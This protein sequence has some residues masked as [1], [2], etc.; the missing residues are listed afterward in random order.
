[1]PGERG[2]RPERLRAGSVAARV[3]GTVG[4]VLV[5]A[6]NIIGGNG[7]LGLVAFTLWALLPYG[8]LAVA[9]PAL[10]GSW[11][12]AGAGAAMLAVEAGVRASVFLHPRG[13]TAAVALVFSPILVAVS[14]VPGGVGGWLV[15]RAWRTGHLPLRIAGVIA[16]ATALGLTVLGLA[17]PD[18]FPT[19]VLRRRSTLARIGEPRIVHG[20]SAFEQVPVSD[21]A[22]WYV[23]GALDE[24]PGEAIA[25]VDN[26]GA[27]LLDPGDFRAR[28]HVDFG[29]VHGGIWNWFSTLARLDGHLVVVQ[30]GGGYSDVE[31]QE[32]DGRV[33]WSYRPDPDL[34]PTALK[35]ADLDG[36][37]ELEFYASDHSATVRLD[38]A[39][40]EV[41][42]RPTHMAHLVGVA[43]RTPASRAWVVAAESGRRVLIWDETGQLLAE[44]PLA[45][46]DAVYGVV[47]WPEARALVMGGAAARGIALDGTPLFEIPLGDFYLSDV[48]AVQLTPGAPPHLALVGSA[49]RDVGRWRLLLVSSERELVYDEIL[50]RYV[51][52]LK[53]RRA[54]GGETL[55]VGGGGLRA[56]RPR[57]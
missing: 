46:R 25:V 39:G 8:L 54:D 44:L 33:L 56:L 12:A 20:A 30:T 21:R 53:A 57:R 47:D 15:G 50:D 13:S 42:R 40:R 36:D 29:N 32:V 26:R 23:A 51:R 17:R 4:T 10:P 43:G 14:G 27:D 5:I 38:G 28:R 3:A 24:W 7:S 41:W 19:A 34:P 16:A 9:G 2:E 31:V 1:M 22:A 37:G 48:L 55:F 45:A 6:T 35:P 49:P 52:L 18:L 11:C